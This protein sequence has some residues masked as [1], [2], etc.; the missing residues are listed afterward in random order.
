[1]YALIV[2]YKIL[3]VIDAMNAITAR[4]VTLAKDVVF[5]GLHVAHMSAGIVRF[6]TIDS[7]N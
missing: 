1:M 7:K 2:Q 5:A 6:L 4:L 3:Y